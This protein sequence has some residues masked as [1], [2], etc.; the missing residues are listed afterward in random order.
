MKGLS[1]VDTMQLRFAEAPLRD[2]MTGTGNLY[3]MVYQFSKGIIKKPP[4]QRNL[5]WTVIQKIAWVERLRSDIPPVG[6]IVTYQ[7][8]SGHNRDIYLNDGYQRISTTLDYLSEPYKYD[9][10]SA[11]TAELV[12]RK[13]AMPIEHRHYPTVEFACSDFRGLNLGTGLLPFDYCRGFLCY[14]PNYET[15]ESDL[16]QLHTIIPKHEAMIMGKN[17]RTNSDDR[18]KNFLRDDYALFYRFISNRT[19]VP[20]FKVATASVPN[21]LKS[22][23]IIEKVLADYLQTMQPS[24]VKEAIHLFQQL[25]ARET[26]LIEDIWFDKLNHKRDEKGINS[27]L[28]RWILETAIIKRNCKIHQSIWEIFVEGLLNMSQG[29]SQLIDKEQPHPCVYTC[30]MGNL[31]HMKGICQAIGSNFYD[32]LVQKR[33]RPSGR[34]FRIGRDASHVKPFSIYG[35]GEVFGEPAGRNQARGAAIVE[36]APMAA[37]A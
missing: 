28:Y 31:G 7:V 16:E 20:Q 17:G 29:N 5:V 4:H 1:E 8:T 21:M 22:G 27:T 23:N 36:L 24:A 12:T 35:D 14:I 6:T 26:A 18:V 13:C 3:D 25:V 19:D 30:S 33:R 32:E 11:E 34:N 2:V 10:D 37:T 15:I 9:G